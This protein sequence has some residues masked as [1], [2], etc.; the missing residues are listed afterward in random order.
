MNP[1]DLLGTTHLPKPW[2]V[3]SDS[4]NNPPV[5]P[6]PGL[7]L[8]LAAKIEVSSWRL[9]VLLRVSSPRP[10]LRT[11]VISPPAPTSS[12]FGFPLSTGPFALVNKYIKG[13]SVKKRR[14]ENERK[15]ERQGRSPPTPVWS[16]TLWHSHLFP[17]RHLLSIAF[18]HLPA[19]APPLSFPPFP[20]TGLSRLAQEDPV[21]PQP[22][23]CLPGLGLSLFHPGGG[24]HSPKCC[25]P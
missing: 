14:K 25:T 9:P 19:V 17:S 12:I 11:M 24:V 15:G 22:S 3:P 18:A 23:R 5:P 7:A 8:D 16:Q 10:G 21:M 13:S 1:C 20:I 6:V 2:S 4:L